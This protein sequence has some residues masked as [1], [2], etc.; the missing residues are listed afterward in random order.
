MKRKPLPPRKKPMPRGKQLDRTEMRRTAFERREPRARKV[1]WVG[2]KTKDRTRAEER[3]YKANRLVAFERSS[4]CC[5]ACGRPLQ[6]KHFEAHHRQFRSR[7]GP[8]DVWN[9]LVLCHPLDQAGCGWHD[10][11]HNNPVLGRQRGWAISRY[12]DDPHLIPA[13]L[14][15]GRRAR[16]TRDGTYEELEQAA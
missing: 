7:F 8:D 14:F 15:G 16:F 9:L 2:Q 6:P 1:T 4:G 10:R 13:D 11:I 5:E 12:A 3:V